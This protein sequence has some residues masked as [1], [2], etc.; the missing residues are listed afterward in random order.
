MNQKQII[1][2][3]RDALDQFDEAKAKQAGCARKGNCKDEAYCLTCPAR[4]EKERC[5]SVLKEKSETL[6]QLNNRVIAHNE[7]QAL[8]MRIDRLNERNQRKTKSIKKERKPLMATKKEEVVQPKYSRDELTHERYLMHSVEEGKTDNMIRSMYG[9]PKGSFTKIKKDLLAQV[10]TDE[11][12]PLEVAA[13]TEK[14]SDVA[15]RQQLASSE[16]RNEITADLQQQTE[17]TIAELE[18]QLMRANN[19]YTQEQQYTAE[20][21]QMVD[22]LE[23][24]VKAAEV[25]PVT[26]T[27]NEAGPDYKALY[28]QTFDELEKTKIIAHDRL[29]TI[30]GLETKIDDIILSTNN[31]TS[32]FRDYE[33]L[34]LERL[35]QQL[36]AS[37]D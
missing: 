7:G 15:L 1:F 22:F 27:S 19:L 21:K 4:L 24:K 35:L 14:E 3:H 37:R 10:D 6:K 16:K 18:Q 28:E 34:L 13:Q 9:I 33:I 25:Q 30:E 23:N 29:Q 36:Y 31:Q 11:K 2:E 12:E 26:T 32:K 20:L 5:E 17:R 8:Q